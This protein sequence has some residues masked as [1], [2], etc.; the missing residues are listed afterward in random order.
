MPSEGSKC[1]QRFELLERFERLLSFIEAFNEPRVFQ[2]F[3]EACVDRIFHVGLGGFGIFFR[4]I[5][6]NPLVA[7]RQRVIS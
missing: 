5:L 6:K 7:V 4:D 3:N 2:F 1:I